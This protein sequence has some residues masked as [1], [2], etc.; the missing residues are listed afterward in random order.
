MEE[1]EL[2]DNDYNERN[3]TLNCIK[4]IIFDKKNKKINDKLIL[5]VCKK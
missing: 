2:K 4:N 3:K 5:L 1:F